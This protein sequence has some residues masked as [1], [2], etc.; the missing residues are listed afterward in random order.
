MWDCLP[1]AQGAWYKADK[2]VLDTSSIH[3]NTHRQ[4]SLAALKLTTRD[5]YILEP[6]NVSRGPE[7]HGG[8]GGSRAPKSE[9]VDDV[10]G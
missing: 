9:E 6:S 3:R 4:P 5:T 7:S 8:S 10:E 1:H 2:G